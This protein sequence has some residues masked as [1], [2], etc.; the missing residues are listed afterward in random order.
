LG[1]VRLF[2][3]KHSARSFH[4][5][6]RVSL[7]PSL[8]QVE[9]EQVARFVHLRALAPDLKPAPALAVDEVEAEAA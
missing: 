1:R 9:A 5:S 8:H 4:S 2:G 6:T 3:G 7:D